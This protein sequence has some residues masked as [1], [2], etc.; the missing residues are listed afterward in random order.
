MRYAL[1]IALAF[2]F[3]PAVSAQPSQ[4]DPLMLERNRALQLADQGHEAEALDIMLGIIQRA[5][6]FQPAYAHLELLAERAG[7]RKEALTALRA[8]V[9]S[10]PQ[11]ASAWLGLAFL[12]PDT[13][14]MVD[15]YF[16]CAHDAPEAWGCFSNQVWGLK[17]SLHGRLAI[18]D[19]EQRLG[20]PLTTPN[21][22]LLLARYYEVSGHIRRAIE[23]LAR[24]QEPGADLPRKAQL[25]MQLGNCYAHSADTWA[26]AGAHYRHAAEIAREAQDWPVAMSSL[27]NAAIALKGAQAIALFQEALDLAREHQMPSSEVG[28]LLWL[29][30]QYLDEGKLGDALKAAQRGVE[31]S[32]RLHMRGYRIELLL[33]CAGVYRLEGN[34]ERAVAA[35]KEAKRCALAACDTH[36]LGPILRMLGV[37]Y[38]SV[39]DYLKSLQNQ[40]EAV[41]AFASANRHDAAGAQ[42]GNIGELYKSLG[43]YSDALFYDRQSLAIAGRFHDPGEKMRNLISLADVHVRMKQPLPATRLLQEALALDAKTKYPPWKAAALMLQAEV[44]RSSHQPKLAIP[45]VRA[46]LEIFRG[47]SDAESTADALGALGECYLSAGDLGRAS[48]LFTQ[49]LEAASKCKN[50]QL[51]IAA[52]CGLAQV[53]WRRQDLETSLIHL[54]AAAGV[55]ESLRPTAPVAEMQSSFTQQNW[56]VY[57]D[58]VEVLTA[59]HRSK[60][61]AGFDREAFRYAEMGRARAFLDAMAASKSDLD[62]ALTPEQRERHK[63]LSAGLTRALS[64]QLEHDTAANR[65]LLHKAQL[66]LTQWSVEIPVENP[67]YRQTQF[68]EPNDAAQTQ[69]ALAGSG[70][71]LLE[72]MLGDHSSAVWVITADRV[73]MIA[74]P[75][76]SKI[77]AAVHTFR[78]AAESRE[79]PA[80]LESAARRLYRLLLAPAMPVIGRSGRLIIIPDGILYYLP[81]EGLLDRSRHVLEDFTIAYSPSATAYSLMRG[82]KREQPRP[83]GRELLAFGD[84]Q[85]PAGGQR[86]GAA[87]PALVRSIY[88]SAGFKFP[89]LPNSRTEVAGIARLFSPDQQKTYLGLSAT[90]SALFSEKVDSYR[91]LHFATHAMLDERIPAQCGV[92]LTPDGSKGDD[93]I[94]RVNEIVDMKLNADLVVLSACQSGLGRL[95]RGEGMIG[96]TRAFLYAGA[97]SVVVSLWKVDDLATSRFMQ[98]FYKHLREGADIPSALRQAKL[99]MLGSGIPAYRNP[100]F[101]APFVVTGAF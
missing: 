71:A 49:A 32:E 25:E 50:P 45:P 15:A 66:A 30:K 33:R 65:E 40:F 77:E 83:A 100:Y 35:L 98:K 56:K 42:L 29:S 17:Q 2:V 72:Y 8:L 76:R 79:Q 27:S 92:A 52:H 55:V 101:W 14:S 12:S 44:Y 47:R 78:A 3:P 89:P 62:R 59:L 46:A 20:R 1:W 13:T 58:A 11:Y 16:R 75:P 7:K 81:F 87:G 74:L 21:D 68:P 41:R 57:Q 84:P 48:D 6:L 63:Q 69:A 37:E 22:R 94:L 9:R 53:A 38:E 26:E 43:D 67:S 4:P 82:A 28:V 34:H 19:I 73:K 54:R 23:E 70:A 39:G 51:I 60:P 36:H 96:L 86:P 85:F 10:G 95:V 61:D 18:S 99:D 80:G 64:A 24:A 31:I 93:G 91:C 5:P 97:R 90:K 88:R